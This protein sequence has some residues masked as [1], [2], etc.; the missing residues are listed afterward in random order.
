HP[1]AVGA[2]LENA[3]RERAAHLV[4]AMRVLPGRGLGEG[5]AE[6][7]DRARVER[8]R[9][10]RGGELQLCGPLLPPATPRRRMAEAERRQRLVP[11]DLRDLTRVELEELAERRLGRESPLRLEAAPV[12]EH[13]LAVVG[14]D[15]LEG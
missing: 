7:L 12:P 10:H 14:A 1:V 5:G 6:A 11:A 3:L 4:A 15:R 9:P 13:D 8:D 2:A